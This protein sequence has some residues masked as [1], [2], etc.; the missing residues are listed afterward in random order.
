MRNAGAVMGFRGQLYW[1]S[2]L[3]QLYG[4]TAWLGVMK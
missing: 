2:L 1:D 4:L 3:R